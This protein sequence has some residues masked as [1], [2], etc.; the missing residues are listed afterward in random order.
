[1]PLS[2]FLFTYSGNQLITLLWFFLQFSTHDCRPVQGSRTHHFQ[3]STL[4]EDPTQFCRSQKLTMWIFVKCQHTL[5]FISRSPGLKYTK[6]VAAGSFITALPT[7]SSC[8]MAG[9][10]RGEC[11]GRGN[12]K[13]GKGMEEDPTKFRDKSTPCYKLLVNRMQE[14]GL[15]A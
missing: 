13:A 1:M 6:C 14:N 8:F 12:G 5:A 2:G 11:K 10:E 3:G 7:F 15:M 9:N 4:L